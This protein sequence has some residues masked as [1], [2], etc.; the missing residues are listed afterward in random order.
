MKLLCCYTIQYLFLK[1]FD[2]QKAKLPLEL[3]LYIRID[4]DQ[5]RIR[6]RDP[7]GLG[8]GVMLGFVVMMHKVECPKSTSVCKAEI[9]TSLSSPFVLDSSV[10]GSLSFYAPLGL[11]AIETLQAQAR[12]QTM[13]DACSSCRDSEK[14]LLLN[15]ILQRSTFILKR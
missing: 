6:A 5:S 15:T 9:A 8:S 7:T 13:G 14:C 12:L 10:P 11:A 3:F 4:Q 2:L 1:R